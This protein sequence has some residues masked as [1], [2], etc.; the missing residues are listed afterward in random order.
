[1]S[2]TVLAHLTSALDMVVM[3]QVPGGAFVQIGAVAPPPWFD[4]IYRDAGQ[5]GRPTVA[6]AFPVLAT[7]LSE[8]EAFWERHETGRLDSEDFVISEGS[9]EPLPVA[10]TAVA[11]KGRR[12][13]VIQRAAG[14][15]DRQRILQR[16]R[17]QAL[18]HEQV[19]KHVHSLRRPVAALVRLAGELAGTELS[20]AQRDQMSGIR[21]HLDTISRLLDGLPTLP[22]GA[23]PR[24]R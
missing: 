15:E 4:R 17:D 9:G 18:A 23:S 10:A 20:G 1:V 14:F 24:K 6:Q 5:G 2:E 16:A 12:F 22:Q 21:S 11:L 13:L 8:A 3:E 7:F 19:I